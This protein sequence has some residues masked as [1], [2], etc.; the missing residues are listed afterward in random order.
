MS[1]LCSSG[2]S[3]KDAAS[4]C[5]LE[6]REILSPCY[7]SCTAIIANDMPL[8]TGNDGIFCVITSS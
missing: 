8:N 3:G 4:R 2:C 7:F 5:V 1:A 6:M